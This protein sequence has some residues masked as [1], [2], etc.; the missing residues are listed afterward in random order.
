MLAI[1]WVLVIGPILETV[2]PGQATRALALV[3]PIADLSILCCLI[4]A[5]LREAE[6]GPA[7]LPLLIA[8]ALLTIGDATYAALAIQN[9]YVTGHP[10]D[11][12]W[13]GS[14][15]LFGLAAARESVDVAR[16]RLRPVL[17]ARPI[18]PH[19]HPRRVQRPVL[20]LSDAGRL[21]G[22]DDA[23]HRRRLDAARH[24]PALPTRLLMRLAWLLL[25]VRVYVGFQSAAEGH[26]RERQLRVGHATSFRR[27]QQR[28][29]QLEAVRDVTTE[30]TREL[31]LTAV[32]LAD[33]PPLGRA[34]ERAD[35]RRLPL[36]RRG[37]A[38]WSRAPGT[39]SGV[40]RRDPATARRGGGRPGDRAG[41]RRHRERL[42]VRPRGV[43]AAAAARSQVDG[44]AGRAGRLARASLSA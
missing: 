11:V 20:A 38:C 40:V 3:Y 15:V 24:P 29:R 27:E 1:A 34:G 33:H 17:T 7:T 30:L 32:A 37:R 44:R 28:L 10:V 18:A 9:A 25:L 13:F 31:D 4:L 6:D 39:G 19:D 12:V 22:D 2:S 36:G 41:A 23:R 42:P 16:V 5:I 26:R 21:A 8:L 14:L 43:H 35:G